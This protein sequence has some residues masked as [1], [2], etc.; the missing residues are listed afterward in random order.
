M[1]TPN[2]TT[3]QLRNLDWLRA[4]VARH[5]V[6]DVSQA[7]DAFAG[8]QSNPYQFIDDGINEA[9]KKIIRE[10]AD[11]ID[12]DLFKT[13]TQYLWKG[14]QLSFKLPPG[15]N[16]L[17]IM[18][19]L[20]VTGGLPGRQITPTAGY[21]F[22]QEVYW[23]TMDTLNWGNSGPDKDV[24]LLIT[25]RAVAQ[26]LVLPDDEPRLLPWEHRD[27][28]HWQAA[29]LLMMER[30]GDDIPAHVDAHV[31]NATWSFH[32]AIANLPTDSGSYTS[33]PTPVLPTILP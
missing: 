18:S 20:D 10:A 24:Q 13:S 15:L 23:T 32:T 33:E 30:L 12:P 19:F 29:A 4:R 11:G 25:Y 6:A 7:D 1:T 3:T 28:L 26:D 21:N 5:L 8:P 27:L 9:Y 17:S 2:T 31:I 14:S 22:S 16:R